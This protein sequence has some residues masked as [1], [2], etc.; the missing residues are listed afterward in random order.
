MSKIHE[1][2]RTHMGGRLGR[3]L[4]GWIL[5][6]SGFLTL[7]GTTVQLYVDYSRDR[8]FLDTQLNQI[9]TSRVPSLSSALWFLDEAQI[10]AQL[11]GILGLRDIVSARVVTLTGESFFRGVQSTDEPEVRSYPLVYISQEKPEIL[12]TLIV[13]ADRG[14]LLTRLKD[15][16]LVILITQAVQILFISVFIVVIFHILVTRH[17][18]TMAAYTTRLGIGRLHIPLVLGKTVH[19]ERTDEIDTVASAINSMRENLLRDIRERQE[20]EARIT[21]AEAYI[22]NILDSMPSVLVSVD[23]RGRVTQWNLQAARTTGITSKQAIG[24]FFEEIF[25]EAPV[26]MTQILEAIDR[27]EPLRL[28]SLAEQ[29]GDTTVFLDVTVYPLVT[30][31]MRGAVIRV[32]DVS[33]KV[34]MEELM[35]QSAKMLSVG[36]L[37]AGMAHEINNP[38][39]GILQSMQVVRTRI[40]PDFPANRALSD[41]LGFSMEQLW[42]Y[43]ERRGCLHMLDSIQDSGRRAARIVENMLS[44]S[45]KSL[46]KKLPVDMAAL[47]D[48]TVELAVNEH[49]LHFHDIEIVRE[50]AS[51]MPPVPCEESKI[52]QVFYNLLR[53]GA[54][55]MAA[56][57]TASPRFVLRVALQGNMACIE[58]EDNGPGMPEGR[59]KRIFEPFFTTKNVGEGTG[60]GLSVSYFIVV[61]NHGGTLEV[62]SAPGQG[63]LFIIRLPVENAA[64]NRK[65]V[66]A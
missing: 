53:N 8:S 52:Q 11:E 34:R 27:Q 41:E 57:N 54:Q 24:C 1:F 12:G 36:G 4:L 55:A 49:E 35:V 9:Q 43:L 16:V 30:T 13:T 62:D 50:Y 47:L 39:A 33:E 18:Q 3:K 64:E 2:F 6:G 51:D 15:K 58:I 63:A 38:L 17:L 31:K 45:R 25:P 19:P 21:F 42:E 40:A 48:R 61:E 59:R 46:G 14:G 23:T 37:A 60:L 22:R 26:S 44:F 20:T 29:Q 56:A 65:E 28:N 7:L 32:D 5:L 10:T 66:T